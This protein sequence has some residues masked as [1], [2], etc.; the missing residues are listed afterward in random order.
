MQSFLLLFRTRANKRE[1]GRAIQAAWWMLLGVTPCHIL[2]YRRV[3]PGKSRAKG[4]QSLALMDKLANTYFSRNLSFTH[5]HTHTRTCTHT[6]RQFINSISLHTQSWS[7]PLHNCCSN[8]ALHKIYNVLN[9]FKPPKNQTCMPTW[10]RRETP[11][12][13]VS[14]VLHSTQPEMVEMAFCIEGSN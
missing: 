7:C 9:I 1:T 4:W 2:P 13:H 14:G 12:H 11:A 8:S 10:E 6:H 5:T 3:S